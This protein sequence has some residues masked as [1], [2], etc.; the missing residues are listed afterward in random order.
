M[1]MYELVYDVQDIYIFSDPTGF[2]TE[3]DS[4]SQGSESL[5]V[6]L[7]CS[8]TSVRGKQIFIGKLLSAASIT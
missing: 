7:C 2:L 8:D 4:V 5:P 3:A 1:N 6:C